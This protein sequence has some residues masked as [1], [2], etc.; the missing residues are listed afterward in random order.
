MKQITKHLRNP[1]TTCTKTTAKQ[2]LPE[3]WMAALF[4]RM[5]IRYGDLWTKKVGEEQTDLDMTM[6]DWGQVLSSCSGEE[7]KHGLETWKSE[8]PPNVRQ[9]QTA[10]KSATRLGAHE[11]Y[12]AE[13]DPVQDP[14]AAEKAI[15]TMKKSIK[16]AGQAQNP[17]TNNR[18]TMYDQAWFSS[19]GWNATTEKD[20]QLMNKHKKSM[21]AVTL[22]NAL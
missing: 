12:K 4:E 22:D 20:R 6:D 18:I 19:R 7:I 9:F 11:L 5:R 13:P 3:A 15:T 1:G 14:E 17:A 21:P 16:D 2:S 8:Y 10:C